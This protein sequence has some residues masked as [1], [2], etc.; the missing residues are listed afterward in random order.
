LENNMEV[1]SRSLPLNVDVLDADVATLRAHAAAWALLPLEEKIGHLRAMRAGTIEVASAWVERAAEAKGISGTPLVGEEWF[2]GPYALI[3]ALDRLSAT[4]GALARTGTVVPQ[5]SARVDAG[6]RVEVDIFPLETADR[7][8]LNGVRA[9][10]VM[11]AAVSVE[12]LPQQTAHLYRKRDLPTSVML[13]LGAGNISSIAPLDALH[14]LYAQGSVVML[15]LNPVNDYLEP[16]FA[17]IFSSLIDAGY[18]RIATGGADVGAYL[19]ASDD[20]DAIHL[21]GGERTHDAIVFGTGDDAAQ[22]KRAADPLVRKP[23]TSELGNVTPVIVVPGPWSEADV[24]FQAAHVA[25]MK[26]HNAGANCIAAQVLITPQGD[27]G[28]ARFIDAVRDALR[29]APARPTY[30]PGSRE[31]QLGIV[32][33]HPTA[34]SLLPPG[35][36]DSRTFVPGLDPNNRQEPL[37]TTEVFGPVLAQTAL[38]GTS[39]GAFLRNA[40]DFCNAVLAGTLGAAILIHPRTIAELGSAFDDAVRALRYGSVTVRSRSTRGRVWPT[41]WPA[42]P[43]AHFPA[44]RSNTSAAGSARCT[45]RISSTGPRRRSC[46]HP[47]RRSRARSETA[48]ARCFPNRRGSSIMATRKKSAGACSPSS[49]SRHRFV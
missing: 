32:A 3:V 16:F 36:G 17:R 48:N 30:Y 15:K 10:T 23:V 13:V 47:S 33:T 35:G 31:R 14:A 2:S 9:T 21:T 37:F 5:P 7:L 46:A 40:V 12:T 8:L 45:T 49:P 43:G 38:P 44:I 26:L 28:A 41:C 18:L 11:Q 27:P 22:R 42:R 6:E 24:L 4:L 19:C 29:A 34:E 25:T 20:V 39:A 1:G